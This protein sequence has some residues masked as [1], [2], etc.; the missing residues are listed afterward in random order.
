MLDAI[1]SGT[2]LA[3]SSIKVSPQQALGVMAV[4]AAQRVIAEDVAKLPAKLKLSS[5][6]GSITAS[7]QPEHRVLSRIGKEANDVDDG[8]TAMEWIEALVADAALHGVGVHHLNKV[9][10]KTRE[11]TP[12]PYGNWR[13]DQGKW[14]VRLADGAWEVVP[15][16]ELLVLRGPQLGLN[17]TQTA[18]QAI[19][20]A[21]R[22][23]AM[24]TS[25]ARKA[26]RPNGIIS[27]DKINSKDKAQSFVDRI[28]KYFG[29]SSD[30]GLMP[31]DLGE[32]FYTKLS[33]T[34]QELQ[35]EETYSRVVTQIASAYRVQPAR[36]MHA[37]TDHN[38]AS[39]YTW[40][41]IHVQDCV[42][43]WTR[44]FRQSFDKDALGAKRLEE[45]F[46][47]DVAL[48]G[49]LQGA[50][51]DRGKLYVALRTV[52]AM[53]PKTVAMLEDLPTAGVSEDPA[54]PLLTNPNPSAEKD[55]DDA[56]D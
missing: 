32:L 43:P 11:V 50:P 30:G 12:L 38:N 13:N 46:Y 48:Q 34:P 40:N 16:S 8:F 4:F 56:E 25:L 26:G 14:S 54:S 24:M 49:L 21:R 19:D 28:M 35:Q 27:S 51:A 31:I 44:R 15:R 47:C 2:P 1:D 55:G 6:D 22:L 29:P 18:R 10:G 33:L 39:A 41:I 45:G 17:I 5:D 53:A 7:D 23:D 20:L 42:M 37:I 9:G 52:G 3:L 36:L